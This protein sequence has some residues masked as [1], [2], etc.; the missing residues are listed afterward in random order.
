[1]I[2]R[3]RDVATVNARLAEAASSGDTYEVI[4]VARGKVRAMRTGGRWRIR[5]D[6]GGVLTFSAASVVAATPVPRAP[7]PAR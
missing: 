5:L 6:G 2:A 7:R 3:D 1:M 4:L